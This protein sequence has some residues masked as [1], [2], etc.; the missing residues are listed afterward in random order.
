[1]NLTYQD[2]FMS[3]SDQIFIWNLT[4]TFQNCLPTQNREYYE[5][6]EQMNLQIEEYQIVL[7]LYF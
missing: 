1:M 2:L 5:I 6:I 7:F 3:L 4:M